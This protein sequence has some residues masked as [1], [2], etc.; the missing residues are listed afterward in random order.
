MPDDGRATR[1]GATGRLG[2]WS[3][4]SALGAGARAI[5]HIKNGPRRVLVTRAARFR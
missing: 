1:R 2:R 3:A 5:F 4:G